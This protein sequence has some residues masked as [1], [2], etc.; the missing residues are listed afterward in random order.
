PSTRARPS[1]ATAALEES[2]TRPSRKSTRGSANRGKPSQA[3][4]RAVAA[5][6]VTPRARR[7]RAGRS[8]RVQVARS[9]TRRR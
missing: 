6:L 3:K 2:R 7:S 8:A 9:K 1:R 4:E 5:D